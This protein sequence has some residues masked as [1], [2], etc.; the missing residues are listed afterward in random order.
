MKRQQT[1]TGRWQ[2]ARQVRHIRESG[3]R[4]AYPLH[5]CTLTDPQGKVMASGEGKYPAQAFEQMVRQSAR[6]LTAAT[7]EAA[8]PAILTAAESKLERTA[9]ETILSGGTEEQQ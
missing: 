6:W 3:E 5:S 4:L 7:Q 8:R 9:V 2:V 1:A